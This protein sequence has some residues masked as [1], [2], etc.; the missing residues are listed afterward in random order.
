LIRRNFFRTR[1]KAKGKLQGDYREFCIL[2]SFE[3]L[4]RIPIVAVRSNIV[5]LPVTVTFILADWIIKGL[6][7]GRLERIGSII[8]D[9]RTKQIVTWVREIGSQG[10]SLPTNPVGILNLIGSA[11]NV[12]ISTKGFSDVKKQLGGI[13]TQLTGIGQTLL[14][15]K[16]ILVVTT[17]TSILTLG[18]CMIGFAVIAERLYAVEQRLQ[19]A[20]AL[21]K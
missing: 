2:I 6:Q 18:V 7:N 1:Q 19:K 14:V 12:V 13:E 21:L 5:S 20:E 3:K 11:A 15:G 17:A 8:R 9:A 10:A 16:G 4:S